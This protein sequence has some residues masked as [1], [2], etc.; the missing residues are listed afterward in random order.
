MGS[1]LQ[2]NLYWLAGII[3]HLG[4]GGKGDEGLFLFMYNCYKFY[5]GVMDN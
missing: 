3:G 1:I 4:V 2:Q 5:A